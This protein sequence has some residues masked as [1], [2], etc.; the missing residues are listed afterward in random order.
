MDKQDLVKLLSTI[1]YEVT[2]PGK[3]GHLDIPS[4]VGLL[5][6]VNLLGIIN[7]IS[8]HS[9]V[10][11]APMVEN[12]AAETRD[13]LAGLLSSLKLSSGETTNTQNLNPQTLM[14]LL[15]LLANLNKKK[16]EENLEVP[17]VSD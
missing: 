8:T 1:V 11:P 16:N 4:L 12:S 2:V 6:L 17:A 3:N 15:N 7:Y 13:L 10:Q 5:S 9:Q 14:L